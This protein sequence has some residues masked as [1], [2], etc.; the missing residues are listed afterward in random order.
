[1]L[2][3]NNFSTVGNR[4]KYSTKHVQTVSIQPDYVSNLPDKTKNNTKSA[5]HLC[6]AFCWTDCSRLSQK[7]IQCWFL[8]YLLENS[9]SSLLTENLLHCHGFYQNLSSNS[10]WLISTCKLQ[11]NCRE[12]CRLTVMT[13]SSYQVSKLHQI[14]EC[15]FLFSLVKKMGK[16]DKE[17]REL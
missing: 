10:I 8:S 1:L 3:F 7:V 16:I 15:S 13:S 11:L 6:S 2:D 14:V 5:D 17:M 12:L 9:F 4:N